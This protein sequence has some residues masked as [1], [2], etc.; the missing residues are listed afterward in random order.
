MIFNLSQGGVA[1]INVT[2]PSGATITATCQGLTVT[3][4]GACTLEAP[5][6]GTWEVSCVYDGVEKTASIEVIS[7]GSAY[8]T[9]FT[10][11]ATISV[12]TFPG[13][14]ITATKSGQSDLTGT[15][16]NDGNCELSVPAGGLGEWSVAANNGSVSE[17]GTVDVAAYDNS[18][19]VSLLT[20]VPQITIVSGSTTYVYK[21]AAIDNSV[22]KIEPVGITGWKM[23]IRSSCTVTFDR[24]PTNVDIWGIGK[25]G[26]GGGSFYETGGAYGGGGG[27]GGG[28]VVS[29]TYSSASVSGTSYTVTIGDTGSYFGN[30][31]NATNG[32]NGGSPS[33]GSSGGRSGSGSTG[34]W[35]NDHSW[36]PSSGGGG[37]GD[38]GVY[39]FGDSSFDGV[40]YGHGGGGGHHSGG[41]GA[42]YA[43]N[44][45]GG[46]GAGGSS[47]SATAGIVGIICLRSAA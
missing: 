28:K 10:Y 19:P 36:P 1:Y 9:T 31:I 42:S 29:G 20:L 18:Y 13:S 46:A 43:A 2:A 3:G 38:Q 45:S 21:G 12:T 30:L 44:G 5:I 39:A 17:T 22:V 23:W 27:G 34:E 33:G 8:S 37:D 25:G 11:G 15:A 7:F 26:S 40:R 4:S 47:G 24:L 35:V 41:R 14:S 16:D 32:G 6:I